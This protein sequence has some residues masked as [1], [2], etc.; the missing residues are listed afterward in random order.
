MSLIISFQYP[1]TLDILHLH[2]LRS[3]ILEK[4]LVHKSIPGLFLN[5]V[6][7]LHNLKLPYL[8]ES[9]VF[10]IPPVSYTHTEFRFCKILSFVT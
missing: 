3:S 2:S 8:L 1:C 4:C 9:S 5:N 10:Y 7:K 6:G